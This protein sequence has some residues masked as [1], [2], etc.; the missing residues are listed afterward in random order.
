MEIK[1][2]IAKQAKR[3]LTSDQKQNA[4]VELGSLGPSSVISIR[5]L[6]LEDRQPDGRRPRAGFGHLRLEVVRQRILH[7]NESIDSL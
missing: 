7:R 5:R 4:W 1:D 6:Q 3:A 2:A